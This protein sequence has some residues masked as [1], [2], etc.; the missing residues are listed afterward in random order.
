[1]PADRPPLSHEELAQLDAEVAAA[2]DVLQAAG[3]RL[4]GRSPTRDPAA[5]NMGTEG[6]GER[7]TWISVR[8]A[9]GLLLVSE[10]KVRSLMAKGSA[11]D[12]ASA[13]RRTAVDR[14]GGR[15]E[16]L[17]RMERRVTRRSESRR[18]R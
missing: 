11:Q 4:T 3:S 15:A 9:A 5:S 13:P 7:I 1:L 16:T 8:Q 6:S 17:E 10:A 12:E 14:R 18:R 2:I